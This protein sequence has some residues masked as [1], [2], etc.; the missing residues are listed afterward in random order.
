M[1][2]RLRQVD[3]VLVALCAAKSVEK[4]GDIYLDGN[5]HHALYEK[6]LEDAKYEGYNTMPLDN[7]L[8]VIRALEEKD[9]NEV[10]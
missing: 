4:S 9:N 5:T 3:G 10:S 6:F 7:R 1:A 2:I 8:T